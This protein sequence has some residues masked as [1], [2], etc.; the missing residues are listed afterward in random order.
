VIFNFLGLYYLNMMI[1]GFIHFPANDIIKGWVV[2]HEY[3]Y[4][5]EYYIYTYTHKSVY[6][7]A[8]I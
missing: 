5:Y 8:Y 7:Y 4:L 2:F 6:V 3:I 1:S